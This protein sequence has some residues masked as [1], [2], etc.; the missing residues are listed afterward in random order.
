M[1]FDLFK[2]FHEIK[3]SHISGF[4]FEK[5][6]FSSCVRK[7]LCENIS[8]KYHDCHINWRSNSNLGVR[9]GP[10]RLEGSIIVTNLSGS[11]IDTPWVATWDTD[12][13]VHLYRFLPW[14]LHT[15]FYVFISRTVLSFFFLPTG[16]NYKYYFQN[17][18][19]AIESPAEIFPTAKPTED[20][21]WWSPS[22]QLILLMSVEICNK[23]N[24]FCIL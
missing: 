23:F 20:D 5:I 10:S 7:M 14:M 2:T 3:S 15:W 9:D 16:H 6:H 4:F 19:K 21:I 17:Y 1:L 8:C 18:K 13:T 24:R 22:F 12:G 11:P